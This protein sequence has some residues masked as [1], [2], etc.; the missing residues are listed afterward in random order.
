MRPRGGSPP[1]GPASAAARWAQAGQERGSYD[2]MGAVAEVG[3]PRLGFVVVVVLGAAVVAVV[4]VELV[5]P[6]VAW[7]LVAGGLATD[8]SDPAITLTSAPPAG[9]P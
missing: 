7:L 2:G 6:D 9:V 8:R 4:P 1:L 5:V 3:A